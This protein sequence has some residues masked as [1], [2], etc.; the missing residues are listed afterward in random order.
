MAFLSPRGQAKLS[1]LAELQRVADKVHGLT[2]EFAGTRSGEDRVAQQIKSRYRRFKMTLM[3]AGYEQLSQ[4]A[5]SME[6]A[7]GRAGSQRT[8]ARILREG[9]ASIRFQLEMEERMIRQAETVERD[10]GEAK[11][12]K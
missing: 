1:A 11:G 6:I 7:A 9:L 8:K 10:E 2:E 12:E 4:L 3:G 5:A